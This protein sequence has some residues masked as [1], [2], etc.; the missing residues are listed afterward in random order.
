MPAIP[1]L[2]RY[3]DYSSLALKFLIGGGIIAGVTVLSRQVDPKYGGMLVAAPILST[4]AFL[5]TYA[6]AGQETT[7]ALVIAAFWFAIP[8]ILFF[9]ALYL[10]MDRYPLIP[11]IG[12]AYG[13]W[14]ACLLVLNRALAGI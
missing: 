4:V 13:I 12:G 6:E 7:R 8:T 3:M 2:Y 10:L 1:S 5:L 11:S 9:L 14:L